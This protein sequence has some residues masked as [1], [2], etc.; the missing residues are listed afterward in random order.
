LN[1]VAFAPNDVQAEGIFIFAS[2]VWII[3]VLRPNLNWFD[4]TIAS[5]SEF[6]QPS[7][8][9]PI[10]KHTKRGSVSLSM[11]SFWP[12]FRFLTEKT[13]SCCD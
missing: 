1:A 5:P 11:D 8:I 10:G 12:F 2:T 9:M 6:S 13:P 4:A 3:G 7:E